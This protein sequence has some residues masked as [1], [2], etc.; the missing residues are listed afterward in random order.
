MAALAL[1][2]LRRAL[3][4]RFPDALPV[5][6][7]TAAAG[8]GIGALDGLL[9]SAGLPRGRLTAWA[10]GGGATA[11]L[12]SAC[13]AAVGRGERAVWVDCGRHQAADF[14]R[15][16]PLLIRP[17]S[18]R[19][20]LEAAEGLLRSGGLALLVFHGGGREAE[21]EA[22]RLSRAAR[23]GGAALVVVL[24][25]V[26][27]AQLRVASRIAPDGYRWRCNAFGEPVEPVSVRLE[28]DASS[29]GWS[30]RAVVELPVRSHAW[31]SAPEQRLPDRRG[32]P[33]PARWRPPG[34][35]A[36]ST[37]GCP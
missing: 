30:G 35:R 14:W 2:E 28:V 36:G 21:R 9:P 33:P 29:M 10:P 22:V 37:Q 5:S 6:R 13:E 1:S 3:E 4:R 27:V 11:I 26:S 17:A 7:G 15:R 23:A 16:G 31:R 12:R 34:K 24:P 25:T 20:G 8:T 32:A 18:E 19:Q